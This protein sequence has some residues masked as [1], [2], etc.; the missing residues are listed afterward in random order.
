MRPRRF[1]AAEGQATTLAPRSLIVVFAVVGALLVLFL[2]V[3]IVA[4]S[5]SQSPLTLWQAL[6]RTEVR[7]A[8]WLS[9]TGAALA[10]ALAAL[11]GVPLAYLLARRP[12]PGNALV[13][14][15][16]DLPIVIPHIVAGIA[17]LTV[18]GPRGFVGGPLHG[19]GVRFVDTLA[20]TVAAMLFVSAPFMVNAARSGFEAVDPRLEDAARSLGASPLRTFFLISLPLAKRSIVSGAVMSWA[21]AISEFGAVLIIAYYPRVGPVLIYEWLTAY[22]VDK[23]R[24]VAV[25]LLLICVLLFAALRLIAGRHIPGEPESSA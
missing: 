13:Q 16:V 1:C 21:R 24:P 4:M 8:L 25:C 5:V 18:L 2:A 22:G 11:L 20:G 19:L 7:G 6:I 23:A 3:P 14:A 17:L 12:F 9:L 15:V 10:T